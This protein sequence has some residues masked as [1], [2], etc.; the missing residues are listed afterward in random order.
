MIQVQRI[1]FDSIPIKFKKTTH[2]QKIPASFIVDFVVELVQIT[3]LKRSVFVDAVL[4]RE[5]GPVAFKIGFTVCE[6]EFIARQDC[7]WR[8][9]RFIQGQRIG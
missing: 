1:F 4:K 2:L 8:I 9:R 6:E 7:P 5:N 3:K